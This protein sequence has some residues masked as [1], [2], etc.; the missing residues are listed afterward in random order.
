LAVD[1]APELAWTG[2]C[3]PVSEDSIGQHL[4]ELRRDPSAWHMTQPRPQTFSLAGGQAKFALTDAHGGWALPYGSEPTTHIFKP[5]A[6]GFER[7]DIAEHLTMRAAHHVGL[8]V[9]ESRLLDFGGQSVIVVTRFDRAR[10]ADGVRRVHQEDLVQATGIHP[11]SKYENEGG[12]GIAAIVAL[13]RCWLRVRAADRA[14]ETFLRANAFNW[15]VVAPDAHAKN[16]A[17]LHTAQG[18]ELAPLY[19]LSTALCYPDVADPW[20][21][22]L[23]MKVGGNYLCRKVLPRHWARE[24]EAAGLDPEGFL[25]SVHAMAGRLAEAFAQAARESGFTGE[26]ARFAAAL[27]D[28]VAERQADVLRLW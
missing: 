16:Y 8:P 17:L 13:F 12:P 5:G 4:A 14:V 24:A 20:R 3:L 26:D 28:A 27:V 6:E 11:R 9:A 1:D 15:L 10:T 18:P 7:Q 23:A 2:G 21:V 19:D 22:R 25:D